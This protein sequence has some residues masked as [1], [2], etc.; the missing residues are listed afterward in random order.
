MAARRDAK[1][2]EGELALYAKCTWEEDKIRREK[3]FKEKKE[4][5]AEYLIQKRQLE[6]VQNTMRKRY[7]DETLKQE[8]LLL[9]MKIAEDQEKAEKR[10]EVF[11]QKKMQ[12]QK[13]ISK[14]RTQIQRILKRQKE[15]DE[16]TEKVR[17]VIMRKEKEKKSEEAL[18]WISMERRRRIREERR[19]RELKWVTAKNQRDQLKRQCEEDLLNHINLRKIREESQAEKLLSAREWKRRLASDKNNVKKQHHRFLLNRKIDE[20]AEKIDEVR[21][22]IQDKNIKMRI[23][24]EKRE[25]EVLKSKFHARTTANLRQMIQATYAL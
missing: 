20:D 8:K 5:H 22:R 11:H 4:S 14:N 10:H 2:E 23:F 1:I 17:R 25:M 12:M 18:A 9:E 21:Q 19:K 16:E 15:Q 13:S 24:R 3:G 7:K 6:K